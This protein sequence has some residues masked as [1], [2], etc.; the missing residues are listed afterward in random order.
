MRLRS[1]EGSWRSLD[2]CLV[3]SVVFVSVFVSFGVALWL[4]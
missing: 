4:L 3:P 2:G 1:S